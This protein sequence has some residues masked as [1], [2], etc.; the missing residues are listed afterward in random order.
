MFETVQRIQAHE[1][2]SDFMKIAATRDIQGSKEKKHATLSGHIK[3]NTSQNMSKRVRFFATL[4]VQAGDCLLVQ[5]ACVQAMGEIQL[6]KLS[7]FLR[8]LCVYLYIYIF[9]YMRVYL[10]IY[11]CVCIYIYYICFMFSYVYV[12]M[13]VCMY[14][15]IYIQYGDHINYTLS[16][17]SA[18]KRL[19]CRALSVLRP[20]EGKS[21]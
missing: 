17:E 9:V 16:D 1:L 10:Y 4:G 6:G 12:C 18:C 11:I 7:R 13:Y 19:V 8:Y 14:V 15:Y 3:R 21:G 2:S 5:T 20:T